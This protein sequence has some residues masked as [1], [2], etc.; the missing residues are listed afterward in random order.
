MADKYKSK[1]SGV[2]VD[3]IL[4]Q[5]APQKELLNKL[6]EEINTHKTAA[7]LEHPDQSVTPN[8]LQD[9]AVNTQKIRDN[10][11]TTEKIADGA[12]TADKLNDSL[13]QTLNEHADNINSNAE[14]IE[15]IDTRT[16][17]NGQNISAIADEVVKIQE[18]ISSLENRTFDNEET[19]ITHS[20]DISANSADIAINKENISINSDEISKLKELVIKAD[21][22][23]TDFNITDAA[24]MPLESLNI[25]GKTNQVHTTGKN[26]FAFTEAKTITA[27][28]LT[29]TTGINNSYFDISGTATG[30][31]SSE[32]LSCELP[33]GTYTMS[34]YGL[35]GV[36]D[37][38][39][40]KNKNTNTISVGT[41]KNGKAKSFTITE[42]TSFAVAPVIRNTTPYAYDNTPVYIQIEQGDTATDYE[43]YTNGIASPS[44]EC[45]QP[46]ENIG[47]YG[48]IKFEVNTKN[49]FW[50]KEGF[51]TTSVG[52]TAS[53]DAGGSVIKVN[54]KAT[55]N[56]YIGATISTL[57][58]GTYTFSVSGLLG[59]ADY[60]FLKDKDL[61]VYF[62]PA[63]KKGQSA[64]FTLTKNTNLRTG[65]VIPSSSDYTYSNETVCLQIEKGQTAT[66]YEP[67]K[68]QIL[69]IGDEYTFAGIPV[70]SNGNYTDANGQ[71][72]V[73]DEIDFEKGVYVQRINSYTITGTENWTRS[74]VQSSTDGNSRYDVTIAQPPAKGSN[75]LCNYY[76]YKGT[77]ITS[78]IGT[79]V[80]N[81]G[82]NY[83]NLCVVTSHA[84]LDEFKAF[85]AEKYNSDVPVTIQYILAEP[86]ETAI[87]DEVLAVYKELHTNKPTTHIFNDANAYVKVGYIA[88]TKNY[89]DDKI[90]TLIAA[91]IT[92]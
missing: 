52:I 63:I 54:G 86:V 20:Q 66:N 90:N 23:G 68:N 61:D 62:V 56:F 37:Y 89:I 8:K 26:L 84:T 81:S 27:S 78:G 69:E 30:V 11:V 49:L 88:D 45:Q 58:A 35:V 60:M 31:F 14:K 91:I 6:N 72:W 2:D 22:S 57:P 55:D 48:A 53:A 67:C 10:A 71:Q 16:T 75:V 59:N 24:Q 40:L 92:E 3:R 17:V 76:P 77:N 28:G 34:M 38:V 85:L 21:A 50:F 43:P 9:G 19:L 44:P 46:L 18:D 5:V 42:T 32:V 79:W 12:I 65:L 7:I 1:F 13:K 64:T 47:S 36:D 87:P 82:A 15:N 51:N 25:Y 70:T 80:Y 4:S 74:A 83:L 41:L 73:C 39:Y 29:M 33:A